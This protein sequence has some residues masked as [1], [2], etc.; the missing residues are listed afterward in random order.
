MPFPS[1]P[2]CRTSS[3]GRRSPATPD[4][5]P[6]R[7][8]RGA[9][10]IEPDAEFGVGVGRAASAAR[11]TAR[12]RPNLRCSQSSSLVLGMQLGPARRSCFPVSASRMAA[13]TAALRA[14]GWRRRPA[15]Y[16]GR[17]CG[18]RIPLV[19]EPLVGASMGRTV[20]RG[21]TT[22]I[23]AI[24]SAAGPRPPATRPSSRSSSRT[25]EPHPSAMSARA[26]S[27][28]RRCLL[29]R[30]DRGQQVRR[31]RPLAWAARHRAAPDSGSINGPIKI[32]SASPAGGA[33]GRLGPGKRVRVS[34]K[35]PTSTATASP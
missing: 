18:P 9:L 4:P 3:A 10:L 14:E 24:G 12:S 20:S 6:N 22:R 7:A 19:R 2:R 8:H 35:G 25:A 21:R 31:G 11:V 5:V 33:A 29:S 17:G 30:R 23:G 32:L 28:L 34:A 16:D 15:R 27:R 26:P 13:P 1:L